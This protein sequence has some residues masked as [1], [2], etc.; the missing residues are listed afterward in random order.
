[1]RVP[2]DCYRA[3]IAF[4]LRDSALEILQRSNK[5]SHPGTAF[6]R[7]EFECNQGDLLK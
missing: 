2:T 1:M 4:V 3:A 5:I 7:P 6:A